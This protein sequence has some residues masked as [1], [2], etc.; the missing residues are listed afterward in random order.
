MFY[1]VLYDSTVAW[2]R[3]WY[4]EGVRLLVISSGA[5]AVAMAL[6]VLSALNIAS[7]IGLIDQATPKWAAPFVL[8][9][10]GGLWAAHLLYGH[11]RA[12]SA[13]PGSHSNVSAG[14]SRSLALYYLAGSFIAFFLSFVVMIILRR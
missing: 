11:R 1:S 8:P 4:P 5:L 12:R 3:R 14:V 6:Y 9:L 13:A 2:Y 10:I 7:A